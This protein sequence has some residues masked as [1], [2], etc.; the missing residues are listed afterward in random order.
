MFGAV[1]QVKKNFDE[2]TQQSKGY[3]FLNMETAEG[4]AAVENFAI[5]QNYKITMLGRNNVYCAR[6]NKVPEGKKP[7]CMKTKMYVQTMT[8]YFMTMLCKVLNGMEQ[9]K[10]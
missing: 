6:H 7:K 4:A 3:G 8:N 10:Y 2:R 9:Y 5:S 1:K